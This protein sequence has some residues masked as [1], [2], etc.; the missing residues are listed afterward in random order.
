MA[1]RNPLQNLD[2]PNPPVSGVAWRGVLQIPDAE[3]SLRCPGTIIV[4]GEYLTFDVCVPP[5]ISTLRSD[6]IHRRAPA[7][8]PRRTIAAS[9]ASC[10]PTMR[11]TERSH[12]ASALL[13]AGA[14]AERPYSA[15]ALLLGGVW[16]A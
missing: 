3:C 7:E 2:Y 11:R 16:I 1:W 10:T 13:L 4:L 6:R 12:V 14:P 15:T 9:C 8:V 5:G